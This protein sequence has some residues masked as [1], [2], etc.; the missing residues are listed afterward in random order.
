MF[1]VI[2]DGVVQRTDCVSFQDCIAFVDTLPSWT[3]AILTSPYGS[4]HTFHRSQWQ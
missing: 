2:I 1:V 4:T 3:V